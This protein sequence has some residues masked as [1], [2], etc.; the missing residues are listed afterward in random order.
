MY[1]LDLADI[2]RGTLTPR[3]VVELAERL[4][5]GRHLP[6]ALAGGAA[7]FGWDTRTHL[8]ADLV[9]AVHLDAWT[10]VQINSRKPVKAPQRLPRPGEG[11]T[12]RRAPLDLSR[13]PHAQP[14]PDKYRQG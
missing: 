2:W 12:A 13:H 1:G 11:T 4:P 10:L 3:R 6:A 7:H 9:E 8:L 14:L 5:P